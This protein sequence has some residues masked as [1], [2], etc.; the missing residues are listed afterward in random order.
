MAPHLA[1]SQRIQL[2]DMIRLASIPDKTIADIVNCSLRSVVRARA[3]LRV[4]GNLHAPRNSGGRQPC[5]LPHILETLIDHLLMKP[6]LYLDEMADFIWEEFELEVSEYSIRRSL[7]ACKWSKKR[8]RQVAYERDPDLRDA[9]LHELSEYKS[10]QL[11]FV[12]ESGCDTR[13]GVRRTGWAPRGVPP[14]QTARL[15]REQ[16]HQI[17]PAYTQDG[18]LHSWIFQGSTDACLF[19]AFIKEL[20][21]FCGRWPEPHS[22]LVMDNASFHDPHAIRELCDQAGVKLIF[23]APY[24][25]DLNPIEEFFSQL[26]AFIRRHW[27]KQAQN[28]DSFRDFLQ[29]AV[30]VV[31]SDMK[32]AQ[33]HFRNSSIYVD[34]L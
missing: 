18:L 22:V 32:S 19:E 25:P 13:S 9:F 2:R 7:R 17:L 31:G 29:W 1:Q 11:V 6:D 16:R 5:V 4:F 27:R 12:D 33:G 26:K 28:F 14:V 34:H 20:L 21:S 3:N 8:N 24:S 15:H 10:F 23:L 30:N